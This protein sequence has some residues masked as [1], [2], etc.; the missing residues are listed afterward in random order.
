MSKNSGSIQSSNDSETGVSD[1]TLSS[2]GPSVGGNDLQQIQNLL[3]GAQAREIDDN[4]QL[5]EIRIT[6]RL[7]Q[8]SASFESRIESLSAALVDQIDKERSERLSGHDAVVRSVDELRTN[9]NSA[10]SD[11]A[12]QQQQ[13]RLEINEELQASHSKLSSQMESQ[14]D[15]LLNRIQQGDSELDKNKLSRK[16]MAKL[17][18]DLAAGI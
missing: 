18:N 1:A 6:E 8:L 11:I 2:G 3:F 10:L 9:L 5:L 12:Q 16:A 15:Q 4:L 14:K 7:D 13:A 17:L